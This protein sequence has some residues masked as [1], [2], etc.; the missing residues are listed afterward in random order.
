M[1]I[2]QVSKKNTEPNIAHK[3]PIEAM[4]NPMEGTTNKIQPIKL[5]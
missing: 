1:K 5:I 3:F 4:M 2:R